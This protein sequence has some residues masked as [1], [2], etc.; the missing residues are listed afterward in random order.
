MP[1]F[2]FTNVW[3][4]LLGTCEI[5]NLGALT[6]GVW[7]LEVLRTSSSS[8]KNSL[9]L[10]LGANMGLRTR[11]VPRRALSSPPPLRLGSIS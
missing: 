6:A 8:Q 5:A 4:P 10:G 9:D 7:A 1:T 11:C 2:P 3:A